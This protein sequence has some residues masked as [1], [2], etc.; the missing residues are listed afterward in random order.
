MYLSSKI[1][2]PSPEAGGQAGMNLDQS[3]FLPSS[4]QSHSPTS[5]SESILVARRSQGQ[6]SGKGFVTDVEVDVSETTSPERSIQTMAIH[7]LLACRRSL[8][9]SLAYCTVPSAVAPMPYALAAQQAL[10]RHAT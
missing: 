1:P 2:Y 6:R 10:A 5:P 4:A 8:V 3:D 7:V 9:A